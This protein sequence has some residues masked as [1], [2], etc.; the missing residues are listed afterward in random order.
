MKTWVLISLNLIVRDLPNDKK[1]FFNL[2]AWGFLWSFSRDEGCSFSISLDLGFL[3]GL[4][5]EDDLLWGFIIGIYPM[6]IQLRWEMF[7]FNL[8]AWGL[9]RSFSRN[10]GPSFSISLGFWLPKGLMTEDDL[11]WGSTLFI[12]SQFWFCH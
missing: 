5:T 6:I 11:L 2:I 9:L 10:G 3:R 1:M 8:I 7:S 12:L 4:V